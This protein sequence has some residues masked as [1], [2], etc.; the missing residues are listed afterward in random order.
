MTNLILI[1]A[2]KYYFDVINQS[3]YILLQKYF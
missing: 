3:I 1:N 2:L